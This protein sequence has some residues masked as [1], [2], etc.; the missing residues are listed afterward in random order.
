MG[1]GIGKSTR[2]SGIVVKVPE[3]DP[4]DGGDFFI[5]LDCVFVFGCSKIATLSCSKLLPYPEELDFSCG[6][7]CVISQN[8]GLTL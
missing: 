2:P 6:F 7:F 5:I 8:N 4:D 3:E 1:L